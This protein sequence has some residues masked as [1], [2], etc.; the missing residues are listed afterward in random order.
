M[1]LTLTGWLSSA[2]LTNSQAN[3][4]VLDSPLVGSSENGFVLWSLDGYCDATFIYEWRW[5]DAD[6]FTVKAYY[7]R[8]PAAGNDNLPRPEKLAMFA[9][10]KMRLIVI[11]GPGAAKNLQYS[12]SWQRVG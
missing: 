10:E 12:M 2:V 5:I 3:D 11:T 8:A 4:I 9:G 6:G 1:A 7:R